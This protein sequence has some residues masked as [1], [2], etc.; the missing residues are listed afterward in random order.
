M[1]LGCCQLHNMERKTC[2]NHW[3]EPLSGSLLWRVF[4]YQHKVLAFPVNSTTVSQVIIRVP[5]RCECKRA[6]WGVNL[7]FL[8][9]CGREGSGT[10]LQCSCL[11]NPRDRGAWWAAIYGVAQG[12]TRLNRLSSSSRRLW[13]DQLLCKSRTQLLGLFLPLFQLRFILSPPRKW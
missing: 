9:G 3:W 5:D 11:E 6:P 2:N 13:P 12:R 1:A 8:E 4:S 10:P 7:S